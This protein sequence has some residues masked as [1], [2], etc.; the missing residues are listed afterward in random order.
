VRNPVTVLK[1]TVTAAKEKFRSRR[2]ASERKRTERQGGKCWFPVFGYFDENLLIEMLSDMTGKLRKEYTW[3]KTIGV[4]QYAAGT[5]T[6]PWTIRRVH[7]LDDFIKHLRLD[8]TKP[9]ELRFREPDHQDVGSSKAVVSFI[10][11]VVRLDL[12]PN[13]EGLCSAFLEPSKWT[14]WLRLNC[15]D[16]TVSGKVG[17]ATSN[18]GTVWKNCLVLGVRAPGKPQVIKPV[19]VLLLDECTAVSSRRPSA[20]FDRLIDS[21][22]KAR[23]V[24]AGDA[25]DR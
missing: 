22:R 7:H 10:S 17:G 16:P 20:H 3:A 12:L 25:A 9:E 14:L 11:D 23:I 8:E 21:G 13:N 24:A 18:G 4:G 1:N 15:L 5:E 2:D 19:Y 6:T